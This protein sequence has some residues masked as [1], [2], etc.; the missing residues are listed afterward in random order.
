MPHSP[1]RPRR[2]ALALALGATAL[3]AAAVPAAHAVPV[4]VKLRVEGRSSTIYEKPVTTDGHAVTTAS[5]GTHKC[6][7]TNGGANPSPGA[8]STATLDDGAKQG[9]FTFD[10]TY[11]PGFD[12][13]FINRV[14]PDSNSSSAF[15][16]H[17]QNFELSQVGGCQQRVTTGDEVLWTFDAFSKKHALKLAGPASASTGQAFQVRVTDGANGA[18]LAGASV[19][20]RLTDTGGRATLSYSNP[21]IYRLKATRADSVRSP[22]L[23]VCVDPLGAPPCTSGDKSSPEVEL[24][25]AGAA[26]GYA[27]DRFTSRTVQISWQGDDGTGSGVA[28]YEV[29]ARETGAAASSAANGWRSLLR[30]TK[31]VSTRFRGGSGRRYEFRVTAIDRAGNRRSA[32]GNDLLIPVDDRDRSLIRFSRGWKRL[33]RK[34][35]W[36]RFVVRSIRRGASARLRFRGRRMALIGRRLPKGGKLRVTID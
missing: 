17:F 5:G 16:G 33:Q 18:P 21:G 8:T 25:A 7:G 14:G 24:L 2:V 35:A 22:L 20:G 29:D 30:G 31:R 13:F 27:S 15:W 28:A 11:S 4:S 10:G 12:D 19:G 9:G 26:G 36:G 23:T 32:T 34:G 6:D 3:T 1:T